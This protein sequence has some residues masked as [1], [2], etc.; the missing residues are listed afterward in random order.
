MLWRLRSDLPGRGKEEIARELAPIVRALP[1]DTGVI[2]RV[3]VGMNTAR[4]PEAYDMCVQAEF[5][6][7]QAF[8]VFLTH[9]AH[10]RLGVL[11][12]DVRESW[13]V[14]DYEV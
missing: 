4:I 10:L 6:D 3:E 13:A 1:A 11:L 14:V 12:K 5:T 2:R 9:P 7:A 8:A